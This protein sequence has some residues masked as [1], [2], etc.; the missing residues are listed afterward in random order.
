MNLHTVL[1]ASGSVGRAV[2]QELKRKKLPIRAVS[3]STSFEGAEN[4]R[5]DL[6][7]ASTARQAIQGSS[8]VYLCVGLPYRSDVWQR[9]WP[10]LMQN[11]IEACAES[12]A[13]LIFLDNVYLYGPPPLPIPF[14]E[15]TP[16]HPSSQKGKVRKEIFEM[17]QRAMEAGK[18]QGVVGRSADFYG[19][20]ANFSPFYI[21]FLER[22]LKGKAPQSLYPLDV[23]HTYAH[24]GD[25]GRALLA[26]ALDPTTH[27]QAW[28]LP[29]SEPMSI[30]EA[31]ALFNQALGTDF[32]VSVMPPFMQKMLSLFIRPLKEVQEMRYQFEGEYRMSDQKFR[33]HFPSFRVTPFAEGVAEMVASFQPN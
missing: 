6:L 2:I 12:G 20:N 26:L 21:S 33:T 1:G 9:D 13:V 23:P 16:Q 25:N 10:R 22:M 4:M 7:Q 3:R 19:P 27:G 24:V 17:M 29:V 8:H 30:T 32:Q 11:V 14:D 18:I 28:H 5:A 31:N 15:Q